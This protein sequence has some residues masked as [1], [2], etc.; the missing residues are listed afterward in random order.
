[1]VSPYTV[2]TLWC[3][4]YHTLK[5]TPDTYPILI[6]LLVL[7]DHTTT[8]VMWQF[9]YLFN[10]SSDCARLWDIVN[11]KHENVWT[12]IVEGPIL[13]YFSLSAYLCVFLSLYLFGLS[14]CLSICL[15]RQFSIHILLYCQN[16]YTRHNFDDLQTYYHKTINEVMLNNHDNNLLIYKYGF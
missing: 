3:R 11:V 7:S 13:L 1:M 16:F 2:H 14:V 8:D 5:Y 15:P 9:N 4:L 10:M 12:T 6:L